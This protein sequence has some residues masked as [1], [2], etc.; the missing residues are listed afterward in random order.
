VCP[1][2]NINWLCCSE[3]QLLLN[4]WRMR[5][6]QIHCKAKC[7]DPFRFFSQHRQMRLISF[8]EQTLAMLRAAGYVVTTMVQVRVTDF[9]PLKSIYHAY[10]HSIIKYGKI[11][12]CKSSKRGK[13]SL[14]KKKMIRIT[15]VCVC[16][17]V[18][19]CPGAPLCVCACVCVCDQNYGW[20]TSQNLMSKS[21]STSRNSIC[22]VPTHILS[23]QKLIFSN[24]EYFPNKFFC[25][26]N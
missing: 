23:L 5:S 20:C 6:T 8:F 22:S 2:A 25:I 7:R 11:F 18:R 24:Q 16:A 10:F 21:V 13:T 4:L 14:F 19:T 3:R 26:Q 9:N 15:A 17:R 1:I 12:C